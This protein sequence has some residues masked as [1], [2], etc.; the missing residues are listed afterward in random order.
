MEGGVGLWG[1]RRRSLHFGRDDWDQACGSAGNQRCAPTRFRVKF[2]V[3]GVTGSSTPTDAWM[4]FV[5]VGKVPLCP[6]AP[7]FEGGDHRNKTGLVP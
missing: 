1:Q 2:W 7:F 5:F 3:G 6:S 4:I